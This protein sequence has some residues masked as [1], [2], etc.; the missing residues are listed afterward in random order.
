[1][2]ATH[3]SSKMLTNSEEDDFCRKAYLTQKQFL[4]AFLNKKVTFRCSTIDV[5]KTIFFKNAD[6]LEEE[7]FCRKACLTQRQVFVAYLQER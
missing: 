1:M 7:D 4:V 6:K 3:F 5:G 2:L